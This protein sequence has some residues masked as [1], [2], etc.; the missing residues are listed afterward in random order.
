MEEGRIVIDV[1]TQ[2]FRFT[3]SSPI[4]HRE[5]VTLAGGSV[6]GMVTNS[7]WANLLETIPAAVSMIDIRRP[8]YSVFIELVSPGNTSLSSTTG[9]RE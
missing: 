5:A 2:T 7:L 6:S 8:P 9:L 1:E 3:P 4:N